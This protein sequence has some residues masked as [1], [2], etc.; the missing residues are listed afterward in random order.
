MVLMVHG[1]CCASARPPH[2]VRHLKPFAER[3]F[4]LRFK[5][6]FF[7]VRS[8]LII[9]CSEQQFILNEQLTLR[10]GAMLWAGALRR[11]ETTGHP[12]PY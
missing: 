10:A 11:L 5:I 4:V 12:V 1:M 6:T 8:R 3:R 9:G 7:L 2:P